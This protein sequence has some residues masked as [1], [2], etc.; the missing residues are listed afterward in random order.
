MRNAARDLEFEKAAK[1]RDRIA[2]LR[3][4]PMNE[5]AARKGLDSTDI[6]RS[7]NPWKRWATAASS[8][9]FSPCSCLPSMLTRG[10]AKRQYSRAATSSATI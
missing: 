5:D 4:G 10:F 3:S 2:Q 8:R 1:L 9:T 7:F 6:G